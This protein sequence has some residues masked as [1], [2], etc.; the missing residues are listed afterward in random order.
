MSLGPIG[1]TMDGGSERADDRSVDSATVHLRQTHDWSK[2][3]PSVA[4]VEALAGLETV[5][6][7]A[8]ATEF[9]VVLYE[10]VDPE[11]LD[12]IVRGGGTTAVTVSID[13]YRL[14]FEADELVVTGAEG[15]SDG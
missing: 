9:D 13:G 5:D 4:A 7:I 14:H 11:A 15:T 1:S 10:Y 3:P 8:L 2:T 12:A 6:P